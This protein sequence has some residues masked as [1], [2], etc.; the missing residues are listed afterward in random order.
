MKWPDWWEPDLRE[1]GKG[2][3]APAVA[4]NL[5]E[6]KP[7]DTVRINFTEYM[8]AA[9]SERQWR[10][11]IHYSRYYDALPVEDREMMRKPIERRG[12]PSRNGGLDPTPNDWGEG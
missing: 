3:R 2:W 1:R 10:E 6:P 4:R 9:E 8:A 7:P 11:E 5:T 12:G